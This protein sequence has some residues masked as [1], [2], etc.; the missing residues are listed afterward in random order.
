MAFTETSG[1]HNEVIQMTAMPIAE[2]AHPSIF[3]R[4][5]I[6]ATACN[7]RYPELS[8]APLTQE[9]IN[10]GRKIAEKHGRTK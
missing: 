2:T 7:R 5:T 3:H 8:A 9:Q 6:S 4:M 10:L 1:T